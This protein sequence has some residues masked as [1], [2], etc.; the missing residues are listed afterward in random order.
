MNGFGNNT[1][2]SN[3]FRPN[4]GFNNKLSRPIPTGNNIRPMGGIAGINNMPKNIAGVENRTHDV[5]GVSNINFHRESPFKHVNP[6][7]GGAKRVMNSKGQ[8]IIQND[9]RGIKNFDN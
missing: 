8:N 7:Q 4:N 3:G 1:F 6:G 9:M 5:A 2:G